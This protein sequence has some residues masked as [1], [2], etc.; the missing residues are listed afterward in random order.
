MRASAE[1]VACPTFIQ[2]MKIGQRCYNL[3]LFRWSTNLVA[4][5]QQF[6]IFTTEQV[7]LFKCSPCDISYLRCGSDEAIESGKL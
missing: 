2:M 4:E 6:V 3:C 5:S 1:N 7:T